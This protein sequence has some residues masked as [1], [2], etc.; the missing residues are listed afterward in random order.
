VHRATF[1]SDDL[2]RRFSDDGAVVLSLFTPDRVAEL[3]DEVLRLYTGSRS[4]WHSSNESRDHE[5]RQRVHDAL[6]DV[7]TDAL[8]GTLDDYRL[9]NTSILVKWPGEDGAMGTH[10]DWTFV[11]E[12]RFRSVTVW[13]PL[14]DVEQRNGA[15]ELLPGSHRVLTHARCSPSLPETY[16]D[17]LRGLGD[18]DLASWPLSA[19]SAIALDHAVAHRSPPNW[20]DAPRIAIAGAF[21]PTEAVLQHHYRD[22]SGRIWAFDIPDAAWFQ[23]FDIGQ[24]PHDVPCQGE[25][26]FAPTGLSAPELLDRCRPADVGPQADPDP[27]APDPAAP[28][29]APRSRLSGLWRSLRSRSAPAIDPPE[30]EATVVT[31]LRPRTFQ[32]NALEVQFREQGY[33]VVDLLDPAACADLRAAYEDLEH[34]NQWDGEFATGFHTTMYDER[35]EYRRAV[36]SLIGGALQPALEPILA[37]HRLCLA[38]FTV[39]LPGGDPVPGHLDWNFVDEAVASSATVWCALEDVPEEHGALTMLRGSHRNVDFIRPVNVRDYDR[40]TSLASG[41]RVPV[42][43]RAGQA[44]IMDNRMVHGS[45]TNRSD[46]TRVAASVV[47]APRSVPLNHYWID[48]DGDLVQF[49]IEPDFFL[50]YEIGKDPTAS[51]GVVSR[52]VVHGVEFA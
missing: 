3:R 18:G 31:D 30:V 8:S 2:Q 48:D 5:Y 38:N 37:D 1:V 47:V 25:R 45:L 10:Q 49:V 44:V 9:F 51:K 13:C 19:G 17:P 39:K 46:R 36:F 14:V 33:L 20:T 15:L 28:S 16:D 7:F 21:V 12:D 34:G 43:V 42:P 29:A 23:T 52:S 6:A 32:A 11:Q 41:D 4:G 26:P 24:R 27:A 35:V 40:H 22:P 50:D